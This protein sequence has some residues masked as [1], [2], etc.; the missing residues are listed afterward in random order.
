MFARDAM[1]T[2]ECHLSTLSGQIDDGDESNRWLERWVA[3]RNGCSET[4]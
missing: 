3:P 4:K 2:G 1:E